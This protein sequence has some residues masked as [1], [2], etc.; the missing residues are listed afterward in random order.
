MVVEVVVVAEVVA[1]AVVVVVVV[2]V[3][4]NFALSGSQRVCRG[5]RSMAIARAARIVAGQC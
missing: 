2:V 4:L 3:G 1:V 5:E